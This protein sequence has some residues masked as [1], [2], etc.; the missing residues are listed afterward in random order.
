MR[1]CQCFQLITQT[2]AR[3]RTVLAQ[4]PRG[5]EELRQLA[6]NFAR[7]VFGGY[8]LLPLNTSLS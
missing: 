8:H 7:F 2:L 4:K 3:S 5:A 6:L 1:T